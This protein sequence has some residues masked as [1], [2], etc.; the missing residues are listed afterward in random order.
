MLE[1]FQ[2]SARMQ[3]EM[4]AEDMKLNKRYASV[5]PISASHPLKMSPMS[6][7]RFALLGM[8]EGVEP[9]RNRSSL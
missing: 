3:D 1:D 9:D 8:T 2:D 6:P 7:D 5:V 4:E